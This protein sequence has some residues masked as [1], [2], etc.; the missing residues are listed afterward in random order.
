MDL[1]VQ[2][3]VQWQIYLEHHNEQTGSVKSTD[4][5]TI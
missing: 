4:F 2:N 5:M 1:I 3:K